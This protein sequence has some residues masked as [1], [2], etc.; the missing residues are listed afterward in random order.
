M[1][2]KEHTILKEISEKLSNNPRILRIIA[3]GSRVRGDFR[4]DSDMD[5]LVIVDRKDT[6]IKN[7]IINLFY[8]YELEKDMSFAI[9]ILSF[10]EFRFG[11]KLGSSFIRNIKKE[12]LILYDAERR[13][14]ESTVK[15]QT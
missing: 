12:G 10:E 4:G 5:I 13:R 14:K 7:N 3:F 8:S 6:T 2:K 9:T 11:E 15:T 1:F